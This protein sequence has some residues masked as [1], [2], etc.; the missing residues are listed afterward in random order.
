MKQA[1]EQ[2]ALEARIFERER[3]SSTRNSTA[4]AQSQSTAMDE[5]L[6]N[7]RRIK[8]DFLGAG[9]FNDLSLEETFLSNGAILSSHD[10]ALDNITLEYL[11]YAFY[12]DPDGYDLC[13]YDYFDESE[14]VIQD[15][16]FSTWRDDWVSLLVA[17]NSSF[18]CILSL[19]QKRACF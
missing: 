4:V 5:V 16:P 8:S 11:R 12:T 2:S 18:D 17:D 1:L 10:D 15:F 19:Q 13:G 3:L 7:Q 9:P 6:D 14:R